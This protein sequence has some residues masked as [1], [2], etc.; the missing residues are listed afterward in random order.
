MTQPVRM[1]ARRASRVDR[2]GGWSRWPG[3]RANSA[4]EVPMIA[5]LPRVRSRRD[6]PPRTTVSRFSANRPEYWCRPRSPGAA[7]AFVG[8]FHNLVPGEVLHHPVSLEGA[9]LQLKGL[10][11]T[12]TIFHHFAQP[13]LDHLAKS[14]IVLR[15]VALGFP[16]QRVRD[17]HGG[18]HALKLPWP[19]HIYG[20]Y[21]MGVWVAPV[22]CWRLDSPFSQRL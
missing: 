6:P 16:E 18:L 22:K 7:A 13:G 17:F 3:T 12:G 1:L 20:L 19:T 15:R 14:E 21:N 10:L 8:H 11:R 2:S 5:S 9:L 4:M